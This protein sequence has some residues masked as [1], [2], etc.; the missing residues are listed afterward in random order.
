MNT[1]KI[2]PIQTWSPESGSISLDTLYLKDFFHYFFNGD[3]GMVSYSL[4]NSSTNVEFFQNNIAIPAS[5]VQNWG[6]SDDII[7][8]YVASELGFVF[9]T[10]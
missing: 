6:A 1:R 2:Q 9:V 8:N 7:W 10:P 5:I 4:I 3:G